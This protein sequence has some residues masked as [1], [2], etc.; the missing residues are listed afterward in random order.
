MIT[1][2][3]HILLSIAAH[4]GPGVY[5]AVNAS[6]SA[7]DKYAKPHTDGTRR[8]FVCNVIIG[9][10]TKG[11]KKMKAAPE[12]PSDTNKRYDTLVDDE[13]NPTIYVA[14]KDGQAYPEYVITYTKQ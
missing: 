5:F 2:T 10:Y 1:Y 7:Q 9:E 6:Y 4:F 11:T 14:M 3:C 8:M 13:S 12:L